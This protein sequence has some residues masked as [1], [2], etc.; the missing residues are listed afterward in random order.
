MAAS[1]LPAYLRKSAATKRSSAPIS[2]TRL[3]A[4]EVRKLPC[5]RTAQ[6]GIGRVPEGRKIFPNLTG[7]ENLAAAPGNR[8]GN[9]N[10]WT[11]QNIHMLFPRLAERGG[12]MGNTLS[13]GEQQ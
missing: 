8:L 4:Q 12:N 11:L 6:R 3:P 2:P 1:S 7:R 5:F 13:G 9:P 10:P